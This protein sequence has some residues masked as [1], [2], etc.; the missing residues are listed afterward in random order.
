MIQLL[1]SDGGQYTSTNS[2]QNKFWMHCNKIKR[3]AVQTFISNSIYDIKM[4]TPYVKLAFV[5][6]DRNLL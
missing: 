4:F 6:N 5:Q 3:V 1:K 2:A